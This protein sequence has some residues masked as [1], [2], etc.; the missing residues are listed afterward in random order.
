MTWP[1]CLLQKWE[2]LYLAEA[3]DVIQV[4]LLKKINDATLQRVLSPNDS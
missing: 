3:I 4:W 2:Y 1:E